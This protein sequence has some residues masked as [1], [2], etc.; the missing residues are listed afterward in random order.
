MRML[1]LHVDHFRCQ[2]TEKGR[3]PLVE[4]GIPAVTDVEDALVVLTS[5]E[6]DDEADPTLVAQRG[7]KE[8]AAI[9][10][11]VKAKTIVLHAF[12]HLFAQ[13]SSPQTAVAVMDATRG[14]LEERGYI[15]HRPPFGWFN[16]LEIKAKGHPL[17]RVARQVGPAADR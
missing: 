6:K 14:L 10:R 13:L 7:A 15:V 2:L 12:A 11:Q 8:I 4:D 3:S 1:M 9:A 16:T 17:S 5:V